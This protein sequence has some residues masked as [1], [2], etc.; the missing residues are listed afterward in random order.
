MKFLNCD[1]FLSILKD[2]F[3][4]A[5][6][7]DPDEMPPYVEFHLGLHCLSKYLVYQYSEW[8]GLIQMVSEDKKP[9]FTGRT[10]SEQAEPKSP[11]I[12]R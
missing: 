1:V 10:L 12:T 8:T 4:L 11:E 9:F 6:S 2:L 5:N 3:I 7:T